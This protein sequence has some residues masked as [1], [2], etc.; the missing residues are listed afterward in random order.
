LLQQAAQDKKEDLEKLR[1][2]NKEA[3]KE[4][5]DGIVSDLRRAGDSSYNDYRFEEALGSYPEAF[6]YTNREN[7]PQLWAATLVYIAA[8]HVELGIR[9]EGQ[10]AKEHLAA[11]VA[12][13]R[14]ALEVLTRQDLPQDWARAQNTLGNVLSEQGIRAEGK[15]ATEL[16]S[17]AVA[18]Y[19]P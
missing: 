10:G 1:R 4:L 12:A 3:E 5:T 11:A 17:Q 13:Y 7:D 6:H 16:L 15:E 18:A 8:A 14:S 19:L 2:K 9:V